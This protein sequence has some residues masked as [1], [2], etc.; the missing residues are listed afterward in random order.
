MRGGVDVAVDQGHP[1][2][3]LAINGETVGPLGEDEVRQRY[4][5]GE[6]DKD[7][8][9]WQEGFEDWLPLGDVEA[10]SDWPDRP[11]AAADDPFASANQDDY[12]AVGASGGMG[13]ASAMHAANQPSLG[14][15]LGAGMGGGLGAGP[16]PQSPRVSK[17]TGQRNENS[18]L[19]SLDS[20]QAL[21]TG[22]GAAAARPAAAA[23]RPGPKGLATAAPSSEGSGLIDIR[24]LGAM[25]NQDQAGPSGA[26]APRI[27][28]DDAALPSFGGAGLGGLAAAPLVPHQAS[29]D[30][31]SG[32]AGAAPPSRSN[33]PL[34]V[35]MAVLI[36]AVL[37]LGAFILLRKQEPVIVEKEVQAPLPSVK[38][39]DKKDDSDAKAKSKDDEEEKDDASD[40]KSD[41]AEGD[42]AGD[43]AA[44]GGKVAAGVSGKGS[45]GSKKRGTKGRSTGKSSTSKDTSVGLPDPKP[46]STGTKKS[47]GGDEDLSVD[48][49]L[50]PAKCGKGGTKKTAKAAP[51]PDP[52]LPQQLTSSDIRSGVDKFKSAARILWSAVRGQARDQGPGAAVDLRLFGHGVVGH[53]AGSLQ[54][55]AAG[56]LR[57]GG[58]QEGD[59]QEVP[60]AFD[61]RALPDHDVASHTWLTTSRIRVLSTSTAASSMPRCMT[62]LTSRATLGWHKIPCSRSGAHS[63]SALR[64]GEQTRAMITLV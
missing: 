30:P 27:G 6:I 52:S 13:A 37:G 55:D 60:E 61:G 31:T 44:D 41:D 1:G 46:R 39:E 62:N 40:D 47:G 12:A 53:R 20:L 28:P 38:D 16:A 49:I 43:E 29:V 22:G 34:Y 25:V 15:G 17:L 45:S 7:T 4:D 21:A 3:H 2:W 35:M 8:A 11:A 18:V 10:F 64:S 63:C 24:A 33:A 59:L 51:A 48:C 26:A 9:I 42:S 56:Q 50:D 54:G 14:G 57:G 19:F 58:A 23:S 36:V 32:M 5:A